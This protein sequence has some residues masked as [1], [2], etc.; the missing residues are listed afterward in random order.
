MSAKPVAVLSSDWHLLPGAWKKYPRVTKD[1]YCSLRQIVDLAIE[2]NVPLVGAGDLFDVKLPPSESVV[3]CGQ[4]MERL[5]QAGLT[6]YYVQGQHEESSPTWMSLFSNTIHIDSF[7]SGK[8][9]VFE[10]FGGMTVCG[11]DIERSAE[12]MADKTEAMKRAGS[13]QLDLF[14]THQVWGDFIK[15][16]NAD[17]FKLRSVDFFRM[18]Y[19]GDCHEYIVDTHL[20]NCVALSTGST[21]MQAVNEDPVKKILVLYDDMTVQSYQLATRPFQLLTVKTKEHLE[22]ILES[23]KEKVLGFEDFD[24]LPEEIRTPLVVVRCNNKLEFG[25][26]RLT[27]KFADWHSEVIPVNFDSAEIANAYSANNDVVDTVDVGDCIQVAV[28]SAENQL[29][30][31]AV[32]LFFSHDVKQELDVMKQEH[33]EETANASDQS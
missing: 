9:K 7:L 27:D 29:Y 8:C 24:S 32:R 17:H 18:V 25:F 30:K 4:Q 1:S 33:L 28:G 22:Q 14:I 31:D 23:S 26:S 20:D 19:S 6:A 13:G 5:K 10:L 12:V 16:G 21:C 2:L 15:K 3:F 11:M